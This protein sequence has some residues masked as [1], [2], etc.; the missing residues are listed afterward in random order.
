[1]EST[2]IVVSSETT[3]FGA[4][5]TIENAQV[6]IITITTTEQPEGL[7]D[8]PELDNFFSKGPGKP[9]VVFSSTP[10]RSS[11][12]QNPP[13]P[14]GNG[15]SSQRGPAHPRQAAPRVMRGASQPSK[16][17]GKKT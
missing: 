12:N 15:S 13:P 3:V 11:G 10:K 5:N 1:M 14:P 17:K 8:E 2:Q 7:L 6:G 4:A 16:D 9:T